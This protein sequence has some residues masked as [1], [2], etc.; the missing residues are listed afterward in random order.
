M[1]V[2]WRFA[3]NA[4]QRLR[5]GK[6]DTRAETGM[7]RAMRTVFSWV[8]LADLS[9][10]AA[11]VG[12]DCTSDLVLA[13]LVQDVRRMPSAFFGTDTLPCFGRCS[14]SGVILTD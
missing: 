13:A 6:L 5:D 7:L 2:R 9:D 10:L 4:E 12:G 1:A 3:H 8:H 14:G 11:R